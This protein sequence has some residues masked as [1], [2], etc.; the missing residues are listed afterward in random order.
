MAAKKKSA[1]R[2]STKAGST[3][4]ASSKK[5]NAPKNTFLGLLTLPFRLIFNCTR[6]FK[7]YLRW[8]LRFS[9]LGL[10]G[11]ATAITLFILI[12]VTRAQF[13][14]MDMVAKMPAR[15]MVYASDNQ[16]ELGRL[17]GDNRYVV[18]YQDVSPYFVQALLAQEDEQFR[19]HNGVHIWG[20]LKIP[21]YYVKYKKVLGSSTITMQLARNS[22]QSITEA[23]GVDRKLL[24]IALAYRIEANYNKD[25]I[26]EHY[27][28]RIFFGHSMYGVEAASR[29]YFEKPSKDLTLSEAAMLAGIIRGPNLFSPF[30]S[31]EKA[32]RE[33]DRALDR[34]V[35]SGFI[36]EQQANQ[37]KQEKLEITPRQRRTIQD[38]YVMDIVDR[39][40]KLILEK[41]N[42]KMGNLKVYTTIDHRLQTASERHME[43]QLRKIERLPGYDH[44]TRSKWLASGSTRAPQYL[45]GSLVCIENESGAV[46]SVVG[47]RSAKESSLDRATQDPN[48][49]KQVGSIVKPFVYLTA[50]NQGLPNQIRDT[51]INGKPRNYDGKYH[52]SISVTRAIAESRNCAAVHAGLFAEKDNVSETLRKAGFKNYDVEDNSYFLGS[53]NATP[54]EVASSFTIFPNQ[55]RRMRPYII[56]EIRDEDDNLIYESGVLPYIAAN[57]YSTSKVRTALEQVTK[58]GTARALQ[59]RLNFRHPCG[60]KTGTSSNAKDAWF[61]GYTESISCAV[62]VGL[63]NPVNIVDNGSG[64]SLALPIW[65]K[66][67]N[68]AKNLGYPMY[69]RAIPRAVP[70]PPIR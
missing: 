5:W 41:N 50:F 2:K 42:I 20:L 59:G 19:E 67:M 3:P 63:D 16:T 14:E 8:P 17:H 27:M 34:M 4:R 30:R 69:P 1:R 61:A 40:L 60:G 70:V 29:T 18:R 46:L 54:W 21:V 66:I 65:A 11:M 62:W 26:L 53:G 64:S 45:Q 39:D 44:Q 68:S 33:R 56:K 31:L 28:N 51:P 12:Y 15:T 48:K 24:E 22:F 49:R 7:F 6:N 35:D 55:G 9:L 58:V 47:G 36:T 37:T 52:S 10:L 23:P 25:Q 43:D 57:A 38:T 32:T 13:Y